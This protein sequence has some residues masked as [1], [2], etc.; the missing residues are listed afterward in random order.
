MD[1]AGGTIQEQDYKT[2]PPDIRSELFRMAE[3]KM[4]LTIFTP[5]YNRA[6]TL[7]RLFRSL[8]RQSVRDFEWLVIDDGSSDGTEAAVSAFM[9]EKPAFPIRYVRQENGGKH[10]AYNRALSLS[11]GE[12]FFCVDS[13]DCLADDAVENILP[14]CEGLGGRRFLVAYKQDRQ[15]RLLSAEFPSVR[16]CTLRELSDKWRCTGEFSLI[17]PTSLARKFPFPEFDGEKFVTESVVY[18]RI[19]EVASVRLLPRA[20]TVCEYQED[21]LSGDPRSLM[22]KNPAGYCLYFMQRIDLAPS[23]RERIVTAGKYHCFGIFAGEKKSRYA[24]RHR[25]SVMLARPLGLLF[26]AYYV[27]KGGF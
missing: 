15:G 24:G 9:E 2:I 20:V 18:D 21:G 22:K 19:G 16:D 12:W 5:A 1:T 6:S 4:K 8:V 27:K 26:R 10:R 14:A 25:L 7:D 13:D 23:L 11:E 3:E 17:F